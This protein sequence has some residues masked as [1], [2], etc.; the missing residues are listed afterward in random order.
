MGEKIKKRR[1]ND[2][3]TVNTS[4]YWCTE[5]SVYIY[6]IAIV[7]EGGDYVASTNIAAASVSR[8]SIPGENTV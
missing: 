4:L 3:Y 5:R 2:E 6:H 7:M 1:G 8:Q